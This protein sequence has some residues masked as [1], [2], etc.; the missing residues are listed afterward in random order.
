MDLNK[1]LTETSWVNDNVNK[2]ERKLL[3]SRERQ[4]ECR[5]FDQASSLG[6]LV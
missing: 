1:D 3:L 4:T 2:A 6:I 5:K